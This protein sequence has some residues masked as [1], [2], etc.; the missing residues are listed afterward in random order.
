MSSEQQQ[1]LQSLLIKSA[2]HWLQPL[3]ELLPLGMHLTP[4]M[5]GK[6]E[7]CSEQQ[8]RPAALSKN[9]SRSQRSGSRHC[10]RPSHFMLVPGLKAYLHV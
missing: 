10:M 8:A 6:Q 1:L 3:S 9:Y 5:E 2:N 4:L 7:H